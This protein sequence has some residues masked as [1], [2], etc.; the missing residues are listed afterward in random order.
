MKLQSCGCDR[1]RTGVSWRAV[2]GE[3]CKRPLRQLMSHTYAH[4]TSGAVC[5]G[6]GAA[7]NFTEVKALQLS[8]WKNRSVL[9]VGDSNLRLLAS[10][11]LPVLHPTSNHTLPCTAPAGWQLTMHNCSKTLGYGCYEC[12]ACC[13][14]TKCD[15]GTRGKRDGG[16]SDRHLGIFAEHELDLDKIPS[17]SFIETWGDWMATCG[18]SHSHSRLGSHTRPRRVCVCAFGAARR[19]PGRTF[20]VC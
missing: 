14:R 19:L 3:R 10:A 5:E 13:G 18:H 7:I 8:L 4:N 20:I 1:R 6:A 2:H 16:A 11:L 12:S 15:R 17:P 9:F